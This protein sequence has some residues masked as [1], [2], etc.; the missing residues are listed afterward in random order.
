[1][2]GVESKW[3]LEK[4]YLKVKQSAV[5]SAVMNCVLPAINFAQVYNRDDRLYSVAV[6]AWLVGGLTGILG[7]TAAESKSSSLL[8]AYVC[9]ATLGAGGLIALQI[10]FDWV[11]SMTCEY[12]QAAF[13]GCGECECAWT[14]SCS[15]SDLDNDTGCGSCRAFSTEVCDDLGVK[16]S[17]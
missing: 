13:F 17:T 16:D 7:V 10:A 5:Q 4:L 9:L 8:T 11:M 1:M 2:L 6:I 15:Q 14:D 12:S 3:T